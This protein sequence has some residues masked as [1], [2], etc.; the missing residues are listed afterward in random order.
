MKKNDLQFLPGIY[1]HML[2]PI[3]RFGLIAWTNL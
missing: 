3:I 1:L 2:L